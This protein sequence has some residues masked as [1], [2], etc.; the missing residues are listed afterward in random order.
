MYAHGRT[1]VYMGV[2]GRTWAYIVRPQKS[3]GILFVGVHVRPCT[4]MGVHLC[5]RTNFLSVYNVRP[6]TPTKKNVYAHKNFTN[7]QNLVKD[8]KIPIKYHFLSIKKYQGCGLR[9]RAATSLRTSKSKWAKWPQFL[10][11]FFYENTAMLLPTR[12][13]FTINETFQMRYCMKIYIKGHH[14]PLVYTHFWFFSSQKKFQ[15]IGN[16]LNKSTRW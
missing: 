11:H 3:V 7:K 5:G 13:D 14:T 15:G 2:H 1:W 8:M 6:C 4:P 12:Y 9:I 16:F 10:S